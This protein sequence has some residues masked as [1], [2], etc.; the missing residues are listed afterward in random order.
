MKSEKKVKKD[1]IKHNLYFIDCAKCGYY[2]VVKFRMENC[3]KCKV[4]LHIR[5]TLY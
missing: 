1:I 5:I 4:N 2:C 3:P